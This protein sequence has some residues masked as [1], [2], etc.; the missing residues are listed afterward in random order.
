[1]SEYDLTDEQ[2]AFEQKLMEGVAPISVGAFLLPM[3]WGPAHGIWITIL[4]YPA[5]L[6]VDNLI[7]GAV[8][9]PNVMSI[10]MS[11]IVCILMVGISLVFARVANAQA[12]HRTI[13]HGKTK[14]SYIKAEKIWA[15][16]AIV[17]AIAVICI[18]TYYNLEIRP[19]AL[20]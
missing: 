1:M 11:V 5:W 20:G 10:S 18:A 14:E 17:V 12:L 3:I 16:V 15:V 13:E 2:I 7:Y 8:H 9:M 6:F 19:Y 4:Y